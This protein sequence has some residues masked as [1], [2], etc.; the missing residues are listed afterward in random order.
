M[1]NSGNPENR[2]PA[3]THHGVPRAL[4]CL[5]QNIACASRA[6][7]SLGRS[8]GC[9]R[10]AIRAALLGLRQNRTFLMGCAK[11]ATSLSPAFD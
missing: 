3:P 4:L 1:E 11:T 7:A 8:F 2:F 6:T 5:G 9:T 10:H